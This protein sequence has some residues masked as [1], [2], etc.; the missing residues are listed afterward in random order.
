MKYRIIFSKIN[1]AWI[2]LNDLIKEKKFRWSNKDPVTFTKWA[3]NEPNNR[4]NED[5]V[6]MR[7]K[8]EWNDKE[9][10]VK[11]HYVCQV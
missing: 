3:K 5:C 2:G 1:D 6:H 11:F 7:S 9:C 4:G 10:D 8:G